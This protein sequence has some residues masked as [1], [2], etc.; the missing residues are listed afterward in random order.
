MGKNTKKG[1]NVLEIILVIALVAAIVVIVVPRFQRANFLSRQNTCFS[2][3]KRVDKQVELWQSMR[4]SLPATIALIAADP[5]F[6]PEGIPVCPVSGDGYFLDDRFRVAG[7]INGNHEPVP[8]GGNGGNGNEPFITWA[9]DGFT[10]NDGSDGSGAAGID[11]ETLSMGIEDA[12]FTVSDFAIEVGIMDPED[13]EGDARL[14]YGFENSYAD[15]IQELDGG[16]YIAIGTTERSDGSGANDMFL[17]RFDEEGNVMWAK[18]YG[19]AGREEARAVQQ[20]TDGGFLMAG[21]RGEQND[22]CVIKVDQDGDLEKWEDKNGNGERDEGEVEMVGWS[23]TYN[24]D[25]KYSATLTIIQTSSEQG[26]RGYVITGVSVRSPL[27]S[28]ISSAVMKLDSNGNID[29]SKLLAG[30]RPGVATSIL[31]NGNYDIMVAGTMRNTDY[32]DIDGFLV[33]MDYST[34]DLLWDGNKKEYKHERYSTVDSLIE[35]F[36]GNYVIAGSAAQ[37]AVLTKT[38][39]EGK[40]IWS[41]TYDEAYNLFCVQETADGGYIAVGSDNPGTEENPV[42]IKIDSEGSVEWSKIY[43][44]GGKEQ[45]TYVWQTGDGGYVFG[46]AMSSFEGSNGNFAFFTIKTDDEGNVHFGEE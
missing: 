6:F 31:Q 18:T 2:N 42:L 12:G 44:G 46:G 34:G 27:T 30:D 32:S 39:S 7:H 26:E 33:K 22:I 5:G 36:E 24:G 23:K 40:K 35:T 28:Q 29:W 45:P 13:Y 4:G 14:F 11:D 3:V 38:D 19:T 25:N 17:V 37:N 21:S 16:G 15:E 8:G 9:W 1:F 20:T 41:Y 10:I 43:S